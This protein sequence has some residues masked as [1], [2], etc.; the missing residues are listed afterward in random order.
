MQRLVND[1]CQ[2]VV[3]VE[4][5]VAWGPLGRICMKIAGIDSDRFRR[6]F[7][8]DRAVAQRVNAHPDRN[9]IGLHV[10]PEDL[11]D[12]DLPR[13]L[14]L[15]LIADHPERDHVVRVIERPCAQLE[16]AVS[17]GIERRTRLLLADDDPIA[18]AMLPDLTVERTCKDASLKRR[19]LQPPV[20][21]PT[22]GLLF[23][24]DQQA[25][26]PLTE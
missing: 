1:L 19:H 2:S 20:V 25:K 23:S 6:E 11:E 26:V 24:L 16:Q 15:I 22:P 13:S 10:A 5:H 21:L 3:H 9:T 12:A 4:S 17:R 8:D 18:E 7:I 14:R